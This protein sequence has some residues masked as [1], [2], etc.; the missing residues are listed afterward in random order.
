MSPTTLCFLLISVLAAVQAETCSGTSAAGF[1]VS[2]YGDSYCCGNIDSR[3][4][5]TQA[6][7]PGLLERT[8]GAIF[9]MAILAGCCFCCFKCCRR[10]PGSVTVINSQPAYVRPMQMAPP[11]QVI[12]NVFQAAPTPAPQINVTTVVQGNQYPAPGNQPNY[13]QGQA[14]GNYPNQPPHNPNYAPQPTNYPPQYATAPP[15]QY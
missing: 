2:C 14:P 15:P 3:S 13:N 11:Q 10:N 9:S 8:I 7:G 4:C 12:N 1:T 5:C 6:T